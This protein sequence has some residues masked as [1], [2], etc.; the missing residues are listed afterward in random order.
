MIAFGRPKNVV[1]DTLRGD[2]RNNRNSNVNSLIM[3]FDTESIQTNDG[4]LDDNDNDATAAADSSASPAPA[5]VPGFAAEQ[6]AA[7]PFKTFESHF[8]F[9]P[10][11]QLEDIDISDEES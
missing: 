8:N 5:P 3:C 11:A 9:P 7:R 4:A 10:L 2:R 1:Q 6:L